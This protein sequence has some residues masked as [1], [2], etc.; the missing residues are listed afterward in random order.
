V[1]A[2]VAARA[3]ALWSASSSPWDEICTAFGLQKTAAPAASSAP[4]PEAPADPRV[5]GDC[6]LCLPGGNPA[7]LPVQPSG[8]P[9]AVERG[10]PRFLFF[11]ISAP[12]PV[13]IPGDA[14]PR[15]PPQYA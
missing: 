6:A 11:F 12:H 2:P 3:V 7:A 10:T 14:R 8:V 13:R 1:L 5:Q 9:P 4:R 15:A